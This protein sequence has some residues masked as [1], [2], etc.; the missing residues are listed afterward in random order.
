[1]KQTKILILLNI[2]FIIGLSAQTNYVSKSILSAADTE[3]LMEMT[4]EVMDS[5]RIYPGQKISE[6]FGSN[7]TGGVLIRPGGRSCYPA[8]WI[9]DYAMSLGCGFVSKE[10]QKHMLHLTASKQC[11]QTWISNNGSMIPMG[12]IADHIRIDDS[13]PIFFPGTYNYNA[14]GEKTWGMFPPYGDQFLFIHM[15]WNYLKTTSET[16][17]LLEEINGIKLIDRLELAFKVPPTRQDGILVYTTD[18]FR[19][20]DF[21]FRD[22]ITITG[23][24]CLPSVLKF[25]ASQE[26]AELFERIGRKDKADNYLKLA[27]RLKIKIP[28]TFSDHRG[29]L[30][31]STGNSSQP[32]VWSTALA[33]YFGILEGEN[34]KKICRFLSDSYKNGTLAYKGNIRHVIT[35]DDFNDSTSWEI[36]LATKNTYQNGAYWGTPTGWVCYAISMVDINVARQL[37]SEYIEELKE[38][39]FRKG[40]EFEAP[41]ECFHPNGH[42]QNPVYLTSVTCPYAAFKKLLN[43]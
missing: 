5:S 27:N 1:M 14:Q 34:M 19:G 7:N 24:L 38:N 4:K 22:V 16:N 9:R 15:A 37:A 2:A 32:D 42:K 33:V 23:D 28:E 13:N 17:F 35:T 41:Y 21:G 43:E 10:E 36:S 20:V 30:L 26:L 3:F 29:M 18:D 25:R 12:A 40:D 31:A 6:E 39:D 8:F 11:D